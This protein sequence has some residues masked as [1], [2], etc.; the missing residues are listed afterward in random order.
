MGTKKRFVRA[1][2]SKPAASARSQSATTRSLRPKGAEVAVPMHQY[3]KEKKRSSLTI[4]C[5]IAGALVVAGTALLL[6]LWGCG[7]SGSTEPK[8]SQGV[9]VERKSDAVKAEPPVDEERTD[10]SEEHE[11][12]MHAKLLE[13]RRL[14]SKV[15][16]L[17]EVNVQQ[18]ES[19]DKRIA[20]LTA[21]LSKLPADV[22]VRLRKLFRVR[23]CP[24]R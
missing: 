7:C 5:W 13:L 4:F 3:Q 19:N 8:S 23:G 18:K 22:K 14:E 1:V 17:N 2:R 16:E 12:L 6:I 20:E 9:E 11:R 21:E 15:R 24:V 10:S